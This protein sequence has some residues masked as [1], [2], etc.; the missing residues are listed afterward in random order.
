MNKAG[1][2]AGQLVISRKGHAFVDHK[3]TI[4]VLDPPSST[5][6]VADA[7]SEHG[8]VAGGF[9][10][11]GSKDFFGF[12]C[13]NGSYT[14]VLLP[15]SYYTEIT[16]VDDNGDYAGIAAQHKGFTSYGFAYI[17]GKMRIYQYPN[18][19][20]TLMV[21]VL[22]PNENFGNFD[23]NPGFGSYHYSHGKYYPLTIPQPFG[24]DPTS[25]D[26]TAVNQNG[27]FVGEVSDINTNQTVG[28]V[29]TCP[30]GP[31]QCLQ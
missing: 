21:K 28:F 22:G 23:L 29:A 4:T 26:I 10:A 7:I 24:S 31:R 1:D 2:I 16:Q 25:S 3:N 30:T 5:Y 12:I 19:K 13:A 14:T 17:S 20:N 15:K 27:D 18:A 11:S 6:S 8:V 9:Y